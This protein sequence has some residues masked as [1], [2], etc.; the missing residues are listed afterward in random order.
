MS[1]ENLALLYSWMGVVI[2]TC[3]I[4]LNNIREDAEASM[5]EPLDFMAY[6]KKKEQSDLIDRLITEHLGNDDIAA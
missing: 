4:V 1:T 6:V 5:R 3:L 2:T